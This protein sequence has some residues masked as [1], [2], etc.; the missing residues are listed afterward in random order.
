MANT[1]S[2]FFAYPSQPQ[3]V[4]EVIRSGI[5][6]I[7]KSNQ[8][9]VKSWEDCRVGGK[10]IIQEICK[11]ISEADLFCAD[12]SAL[13]NNVLFEIG[14]AIALNKRVWLTLDT[15]ITEYSDEFARFRIL[16]TLGYRPARN[17]SELVKRFLEDRPFEDLTDTIFRSEIERA[18][19]SQTG[20]F[21]AYLKAPN[22]TEADSR[23]TNAV[24][25]LS[26]R[27]FTF[28][29]A[30]ADDTSLTLY[31]EK[32]YS[33]AAVLCHFLNPRRTNAKIWNARYSF[34]AG[35]AYGFDKKLLMLAEEEF[36]SPLDY[37]DL[38][39][40][41]STAAKA[42]E[43]FNEW[44]EPVLSSVSK[45]N[46]IQS[47]NVNRV[48]LASGLRA[49][50]LGEYVAENE[51]DQLEGY[52]IETS[53]FLEAL[54][55]RSSIFVGRKGVGKSAN[56]FRL[57]SLLSEDP[58]NIVCEIK[59]VAYEI[60]GVIQL[61][62]K[63]SEKEE[64]TYIFETLWKFLI[65]T[66]IT[67]DVVVTIKNRKVQAGVS[68]EE[69]N[70]LS[71]VEKNKHLIEPEF[72]LRLEA[73]L[74]E[75]QASAQSQS[76]IERTIARSRENVA[77]ALHGGFLNEL[78]GVLIPVLTDKHRVSVLVD[79][80]DKAWDKDTNVD[81]LSHFFLG[82]L[83]A[84]NR[85]SHDLKKF[86]TRAEN[87]NVVLTVFLRADIFHRI[88][89]VA[90]EPD[91]INHYRISWA[92]PMQLI[93]VL[94]ERLRA[95]EDFRVDETELWERYFCKEVQGIPIREFFLR[96]SL[97]RPRDLI[98]LV[99]QALTFAV[100]RRHSK[101]EAEDAMDA[102]KPYSEFAIT[103]VQVEGLVMSGDLEKVL[104]E[105]VGAPPILPKGDIID[106][107]SR[108]DVAP[109]RFDE[110]LDHLCLLGV[111]GMEVSTGD[112]RYVLD[113]VDLRKAKVL[114]S[115]K[116]GEAFREQRF[117]INRPFR[118]FLETTNYLDV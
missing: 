82:L 55:G 4:G 61:F 11:A 47:E 70:L 45:A 53:A 32:I 90:R 75:L 68:E 83:T 104:Y 56:F 33:S 42:V 59:P 85:I 89:S 1:P 114:A 108:V 34:A 41:Y 21:L 64:R 69:N 17:S 50:R 26:I 98:Y 30:E 23:L 93:Q 77:Q 58:R 6:E 118:T 109:E 44:I 84:T 96:E 94:D 79:N 113:E 101:V 62:S 86:K 115:A 99:N 18:L 63:V 81:T 66:Q 37:K 38:I 35:L 16:S 8:A 74:S 12:I 9:K 103:S 71:L 67:R 5:K 72:S 95:L 25:E 39:K 107:M 36:L 117:E 13:N 43:V 87:V 14:Y 22:P 116:Q 19:P 73:C 48:R 88:M 28:D 78:R 29:P 105:F 112:F 92:D 51:E 24:E 76:D 40:K 97:P 20:E 60:E 15:S 91:K 111:L 52:F 31:A 10:F 3:T 7:N 100:N 80:L 102:R 65:L 46:I 106:R 54:N 2:A 110:L 49:L 57:A 27:K